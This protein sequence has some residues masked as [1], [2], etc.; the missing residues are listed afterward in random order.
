MNPYGIWSLIYIKINHNI[1]TYSRSLVAGR[2]FFFVDYRKDPKRFQARPS[3]G[4][5]I[6]TVE[7]KEMDEVC[8]FGTC[9][10]RS[11]LYINN[12]YININNNVN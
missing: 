4:S 7:R 1:H 6:D 8:I 9:Y 2:W 5:R 11:S 10:I 3:Y 12:P